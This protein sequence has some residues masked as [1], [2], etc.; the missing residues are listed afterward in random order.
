MHAENSSFNDGG[1]GQIVKSFI[2]I[3]PNIVISIFFSDL[4]IESVHICDVPGL[5][6]TS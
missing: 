2:K 1:D 6:V 4:V 3:I 5:M